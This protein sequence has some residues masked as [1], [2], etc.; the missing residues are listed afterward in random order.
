MEKMIIALA[1]IAI[2]AIVMLI[3]WPVLRWD[4]S[5]AWAWGWRWHSNFCIRLPWR[6]MR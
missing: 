4:I 1:V 6:P 5:T 3:K 2:A